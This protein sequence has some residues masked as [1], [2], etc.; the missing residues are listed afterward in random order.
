MACARIAALTASCVISCG[1]R[2]R[3]LC[4]SASCCASRLLPLKGLPARAI[5]VSE[6]PTWLGLGLG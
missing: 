5:L 1:M 2:T 3:R 4:C 6:G